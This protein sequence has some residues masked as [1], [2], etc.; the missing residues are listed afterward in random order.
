MQDVLHPIFDAAYDVLGI[1]HDD[2]G[3]QVEAFVLDRW[4]RDQIQAAIDGLDPAEH[5]AAAVALCVLAEVIQKHNPKTT[6]AL[7]GLAATLSS[8]VT[9]ALPRHAASERAGAAKARYDQ[10]RGEIEPRFAA[11]TPPT[12]GA[13]RV[14]VGLQFKLNS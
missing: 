3:R 6:V 5:E 12:A 2:Q 10:F 13:H 14:G 11:P 4:A 8:T 9:R 7:R 1:E